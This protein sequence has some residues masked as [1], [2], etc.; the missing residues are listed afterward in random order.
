M[1]PFAESQHHII[2]P[3]N[4]RGA[5]D[6]RVEHRLH[7]RGRAADDAEHLGRRRLMLQRLAQFRVAL[8]D[9]LEQPHVLDR[10]DRLIGEGFE[11]SLICFSVNGRTSVR[12]IEIAPIATPSRS[13]GVASTVRCGTCWLHCL[14]RKFSFLYCHEVMDV[15]RLAIYNGPS[16][17]RTAS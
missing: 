4:P 10:D 15:N 5:L 6:D 16:R 3:T 17:W 14:H 9:F 8:L 12:R 7:V 1:F 2:N 11:Q 13:N